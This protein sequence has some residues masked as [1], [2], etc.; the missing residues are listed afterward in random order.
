MLLQARTVWYRVFNF[1]LPTMSYL[2]YIQTT[3]SNRC[4]L[5]QDHEETMEHFLIFCSIKYSIW[6]SIFHNFCPEF[7]L[8][9]E[10]IWQ[11]LRFLK[12]PD[13]FPRHL[14]QQLFI[15]VSTSLWY[16]WYFHW[17]FVIHNVPYQPNL[18]ISKIISQVSVLTNEHPLIE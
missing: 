8:Q 17:Q 1:K 9:S 4:R 15:V 14:H 7:N 16:I 3:D 6:K 11:L 10:S 5:C 13:C 18:I 12:L 2:L